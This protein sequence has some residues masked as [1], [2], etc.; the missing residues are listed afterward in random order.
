[1]TS[2]SGRTASNKAKTIFDMTIVDLDLRSV[3]TT[4]LRRAGIE[5]VR[6][7]PK[8]EEEMMKVLTSVRNR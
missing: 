1:M 8:P 6:H 4:R 3:R 7:C 5:T 2:T